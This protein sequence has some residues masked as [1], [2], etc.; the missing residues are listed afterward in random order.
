MRYYIIALNNEIRY[1]N[2]NNE[3]LKAKEEDLTNLKFI[4]FVTSKYGEDKLR[5]YLIQKK[6]IDNIDTPL[7]IV[8]PVMPI[9][10]NELV[11]EYYEI[12]YK[13][14][15]S[16]Y[17]KDNTYLLDEF[18]KNYYSNN[19]FKELSNNIIGQEEIQRIFFFDGYNG[20][21]NNLNYI[22]TRQII[23]VLNNYDSK[24]KINDY[25]KR[26]EDIIKYMKGKTR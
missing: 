12:L 2:F 6:L 15:Y 8:R 5:N 4:D 25:A 14:K 24:R 1:I 13:D 7:C 26:K 19:E 18:K 21:R 3:I 20:R 11:L 10:S 22:Q 16:S 17:L 9:F 23:S